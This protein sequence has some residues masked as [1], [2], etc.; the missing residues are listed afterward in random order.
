MPATVASLR[1]EMPNAVIKVHDVP[2]DTALELLRARKVDLAIAAL[3]VTHKDLADEEIARDRFVLLSSKRSPL[4]MDTSVWSEAAVSSLQLISMRRGT[5]T[6]Q[7]ID[8]AFMKK[9]LP[10]RP[11]LELNNLLTIARFVKAGCGVALMPELAARLVLDKD[12]FI[13]TLAG[14]PERSIGLITRREDEL[15]P[16]AATVMRSMREHADALLGI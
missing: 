11:F 15:P 2:P 3:S 9:N 7:Y 10:F 14:A 13:T 6:R 4:N 12:L 16:L 1:A 5:S 8:A